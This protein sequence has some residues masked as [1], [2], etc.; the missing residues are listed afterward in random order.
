VQKKQKQLNDYDKCCEA[1][2]HFVHLPNLFFC[3]PSP[4][5]QMSF[6]EQDF[7]GPSP[8]ID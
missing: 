4:A 6:A 2:A 5:W 7:G 8:Q 3:D 1:P